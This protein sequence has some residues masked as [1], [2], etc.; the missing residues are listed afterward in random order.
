MYTDLSDCNTPLR[1]SNVAESVTVLTSPD[2]SSRSV[3][4]TWIISPCRIQCVLEVSSNLVPT[5]CVPD[6]L[7]S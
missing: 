3:Y 6:V 4:S 2:A 7:E 1:R 5:P